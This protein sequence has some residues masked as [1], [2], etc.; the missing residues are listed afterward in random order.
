MKKKLAA[1]AAMALLLTGCSAGKAGTAL[2]ACVKAAEEEVGV[3]VNASDIESTNMSDAL[4]EVGIKDERETSDDNALF[5]V[6]GKI[7]YV[8]DGT[9]TRRSMICMVRFNE[10]EPEEPELTLT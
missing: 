3:S 4:Y 1:L 8:Q 2:D 7:T 5:T 6:A 10:G 9:E